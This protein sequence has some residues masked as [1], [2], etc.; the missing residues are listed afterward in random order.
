VFDTER[1]RAAGNGAF[2][3]R[4]GVIALLTSLTCI[5]LAPAVFGF[6]A[7]PDHQIGC[8]AVVDAWHSNGDLT[9][10]EHLLET[11]PTGI[12]PDADNATRAAFAARIRAWEAHP[13]VQRAIATVD[14][15]G[16]KA[17]CIGPARHRL[18][19]S[20]VGLAMNTAAAVGFVL[21]RRR[22]SG[23]SRPRTPA[24]RIEASAGLADL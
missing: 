6:A 7:G 10:A 16:G 14:R 15:S 11:G 5:A 3:R 9:A 23:N 1:D 8:I 18:I 12:P 17:A 2:Y 22:R 13:E 19:I 21:A 4:I 24:L 20:G